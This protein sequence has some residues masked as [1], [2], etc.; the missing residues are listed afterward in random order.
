MKDNTLQQADESV[1]QKIKKRQRRLAFIALVVLVLFGLLLYFVLYI[2]GALG[3]D[4]TQNSQNTYRVESLD[5]YIANNWQEFSLAKYDSEQHTIYLR[6]TLSYTFAQVQ[7]YGDTVYD[8]SYYSSYID[9]VQQIAIGISIDC[10][11]KGCTIILE[12]YTTDE[13]LAYSVTSNATIETY[14][15]S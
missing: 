14:W 10:N 7:K 11:I 4:K 8:E 13:K 3:G 2:G 12:Q 6:G 5:A 1:I 15:N 9:L